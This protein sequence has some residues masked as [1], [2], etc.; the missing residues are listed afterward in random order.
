MQG[1]NPQDLVVDWIPET[2]KN[3]T[4]TSGL[5]N[6]VGCGTISREKRHK[7]H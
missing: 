2:V 4:Q 7:E 1:K 3:D 5:C 6:W